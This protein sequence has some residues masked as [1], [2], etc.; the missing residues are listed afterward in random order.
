VQFF[1][2]GDFRRQGSFVIWPFR[3]HAPLPLASKVSCERRF[4]TVARWLGRSRIGSI[5]V[6]A[7]SELDPIIT[8]CDAKDLPERL[9]RFISERM[10]ST[11]S[12]Q[13]DWGTDDQVMADGQPLLYVV[14]RDRDGDATH[15][16]FH[17][18]LAEFPYRTAAVTAMAAA[19]CLVGS[20]LADVKIPE[21][22]TE[23]LPLFFGFGPVLANAALHEM[24]ETDHASLMHS[25]AWSRI[26]SVSSLEFGYHMALA[27]WNLAARH[28]EVRDLLRLDAR[29]GLDKGIR[30]LQK[31]SDCSF[32]KDF[33]NSAEE[34][35]IGHICIR[36]S[37]R[38]SSVQLATLV[39]LSLASDIDSELFPA[40]ANLLRHRELDIQ[41]LAAET[42][43][44][45]KE[46]PRQIHDE[47]VMQ[48]EN[49]PITLRRAAIA[50][51]RPGFDNDQD[52]Q[53]VLTDVL[54]RTD[55]TTSATCI[56]S[57]LNYESHPDTLVE[58][59]LVALKRMALT[60][61]NA[62]LGNGLDLLQ[63]VHDNPQ[64]ALDETFQ[65]D[66]TSLAILNELLEAKD[67]P[68]SKR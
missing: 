26:G 23:I 61:G 59:V 5:N 12:P 65:N 62:A 15:V 39:D 60:S 14:S 25:W 48:S 31:T 51:L 58:A 34:N 16:T 2:A 11:H 28:Y 38:S 37:H 42:L 68:V 20:E 30:F 52:V 55:A 64:Q 50:G 6:V 45:C 46:L 7:P 21:G 29:E 22:A 3:P 36:L 47:L 49:G 35:S 13:A 66:P 19:E 63:E 53:Q 56:R 27:D 44:R 32:E 17:K 33:L 40:V 67:N 8:S 4:A 18:S 10:Q 43:G 54:F 24:S 57:L 9:F 41:T 1:F